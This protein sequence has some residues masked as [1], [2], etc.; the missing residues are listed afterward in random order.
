MEKVIKPSLSSMPVFPLLYRFQIL[1][2]P[3][4]LLSKDAVHQYHAHS[5]KKEPKSLLQLL[6][7]CILIMKQNTDKQ[8][9]QKDGIEG[10]SQGPF[11]GAWDSGG[12]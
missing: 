8:V 11:P 1:K 5:A 12:Q 2:Q 10:T 4:Q 7:S 9:T 6:R 3:S